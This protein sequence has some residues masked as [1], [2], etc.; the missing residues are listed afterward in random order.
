MINMYRKFFLVFVSIFL[1]FGL[2]QTGFA[3]GSGSEESAEFIPFSIQIDDITHDLVFATY[4]DKIEEFHYDGNNKKLTA[5]MP[6]NW[7]KDFIKLN[8]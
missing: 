5:Q 6:F 8:T 2:T 7:D 4:F 3:G 1:I